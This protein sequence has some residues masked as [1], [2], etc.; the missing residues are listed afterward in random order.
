MCCQTGAVDV[1]Y[2]LVLCVISPDGSTLWIPNKSESVG[3]V[4]VSVND[5]EIDKA[6]EA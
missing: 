1:K 5:S 2:V 3:L 6:I 4:S